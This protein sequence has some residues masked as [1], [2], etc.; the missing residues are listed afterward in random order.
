MKQVKKLIVA[1]L[2]LALI[3]PAPAAN[4]AKKAAGFTVSKKS[5][6]YSST[7]TTK[8]KVKK[9]YKV[10]YTTGKKLSSKKVIK[11][12]KSK[13]FTFTSSKTLRLYAVKSSKKITAKK[14]R[15]IKTKN[16]KK[17]TYI[18]TSS[19]QT[20]VESNSPDSMSASTQAPGSS[21]TATPSSQATA[22]PTEAATSTPDHNPAVPSAPAATQPS[23]A[24]PVTTPGDSGYTGDDADSDYV[25]PTRAD[26]EEE[27]METAGVESETTEIT[28]PAKAPSKK[29][30]TSNYELSKK[31]KLTIT[32]PG[33]YVIQTEDAETVTDG[34]I[35]VD[36]SNDAADGTAHLILNGVNLTS[37]NNTEPT[38]DTGLITI[39]SS[40]TK[41]VITLADG[42]TNTLT[43]TGATGIDK[44]DA[45]S[46]T[47]T[48]GIVCKKTPLTINGSGSLNILSTNGNGIKCTNLLKILDA[49]IAVSGPNDA[50]CGHNG[51]SGKLGVFVKDANLNVHS[52][53]D[54]LK[55]TL[56]ET[57]IADDATLA[58]LGNMEL[59]GGTYLFVSENGDAVSATR[60][61]YL[62][63]VSLNAT[64]KNAAGTTT[65][66]SYK[67]IKAGTTIYVPAT[68][69]TITADT[70]ATYS[71]SRASGDSNDSAADD[72]LHCD[73]YIL[74]EGGSFTLAS[75]DDGI[76]ADAGLVIKNGTINVTAS[77]EGLEGADISIQG[78]DITIVS[79]DDGINAAGGSN[80]SSSS[81]GPGFGGDDFHKGDS[82]SSSQYQ[83]I[84]EGGN[85]NIDASGDG[86]DSNGN[87]FF[88][89]GTVIVN[90]PT[91]NGNGALDYG[92]DADCVCEISGGTLIAAGASGMAVAPTS[93]SSQP[94]VNVIL[95]STQAA[96]TYVVLKDSDGNTVLQAQPS[97]SFQSVVMSC[98][99]LKL[100]STYQIYY[101]SDLSNLTQSGSVTF[102]STSMSTGN[103]SSGGGWNFG[104]GG[105]GGRPGG[106]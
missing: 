60:T 84:I 89:G 28:I 62:N 19:S 5:G 92:D 76:H 64:T 10:Y 80:N 99:D 26:W 103:S 8:V 41:A 56:D 87:I 2:V 22:S 75:G 77:Y 23:T 18:I 15:K 20:A 6:T 55:T 72:T 37:S 40:V 14:L 44:A 36:Y 48:A 57:D 50:A 86:I 38:S 46:T 83:I 39:K 70:T 29:I 1:A 34:L 105:F 78:G 49:T 4:A 100:G 24:Q 69:G 79:R 85:I 32:A 7:V 43:D 27:D 81:M 82:S 59:D 35:E 91:N 61:L 25:A 45:T 33:T 74:I 12:K 11:A 13:S 67:G 63:P 71:A 9:G 30:T 106:R 16:M 17:Y 31:N 102:T 65:D 53:G 96:G 104:G 94:A 73:G 52:D 3:C 95:S 58:D 42:S 66:G 51:I 93:G 97:K 101:G 54:C 21:S 68:A 47:Y 88:K 98:E 90:G